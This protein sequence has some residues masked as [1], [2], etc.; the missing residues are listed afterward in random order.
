MPPLSIYFN[1]LSSPFQETEPEVWREWANS[2]YEGLKHAVS[3]N[4]SIRLALESGRWHAICEGRPFSLWM[5][6]WLGSARYQWVL[7]K[8][9]NFAAPAELERELYVDGI[10]AIGLSMTRIA[11]T[12]GCSLPVAG[13]PWTAHTIGAVEYRLGEKELLQIPC[14]IRHVSSHDHAVHW[15]EEIETW[16]R[17][18]AT[19]NVVAEH[20]G[21]LVLMYPLDHAPPHVHLFNDGTKQT[22]AKYRF[23]FFERLEG[24]PT[25]DAH[26]RKWLND[27]RP[28]LFL[29]WARCL[30]G[31]HPLQIVDP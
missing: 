28:D 1:E 17:T 6:D 22:I 23:D 13:S 19:T 24:P 3:A 10:R 29:S 12:W 21:Y 18:I 20:D 7:S 31:Q 26:F 15:A 9:D 30:R 4:H 11:Q 25:W 16:G 2:L 14:E 27:K 8:I 5:K